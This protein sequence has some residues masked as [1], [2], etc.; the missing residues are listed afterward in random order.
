MRIPHPLKLIAAGIQIALFIVA[1]VLLAMF[2]GCSSITP[3]WDRIQEEIQP[4]TEGEPGQ[5][6]PPAQTGDAIDLASVAWDG[7]DIRA[8]P[9]TID[10]DAAVIGSTVRLAQSGTRTWPDAGKR[11]SDGRVLVANAWVIAKIGDQW[12]AA[13]WEWMAQ[14]QQSKASKAVAGDHVKRSAWPVNWRP[15]SGETIY[16]A[17]SGLCRDAARNVQERSAFREVVWP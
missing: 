6:I 16:L 7:F 15:A 10:L 11:A 12:R 14:N 8:W 3:L 2:T 17:V 9:V 5:P 4:P 1:I 13:T